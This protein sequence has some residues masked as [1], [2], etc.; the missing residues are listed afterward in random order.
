MYAKAQCEMFDR[1]QL[2]HP[3]ICERIKK[4]VDSIGRT[5]VVNAFIY[6][7]STCQLVYRSFLITD[8]RDCPNKSIRLAFS[9]ISLLIKKGND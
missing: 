1:E 6:S 8:S 5:K 7:L 4:A 3:A 2:S 9:V